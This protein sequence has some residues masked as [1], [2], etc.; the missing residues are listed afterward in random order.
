MQE[1]YHK[2]V[3][4]EEGLAEF[5]SIG[6]PVRNYAARTREEYTRDLRELIAFLHGRG[7]SDWSRVSLWDLQVFLGELDIHGAQ[8]ATR[9]RKAHTIKSLFGFL[10]QAGAI[11]KNPTAELIPPHIPEKERRFLREAEYQALLA[12]VDDSR[13][14]A[15]VIVL[16][17][18]GILLSELVT[19]RTFDVQLPQQ[20]T[21]RPEDVGFIRVRRRR[22]DEVSLPL[23]FK[24]CEALSAWLAEREVWVQ[25]RQL[26]SEALFLS[27]IGTPLT[28]RGIRYRIKQYL[29]R[30]QIPGASVRTLRHTMAAHYLARGGDL[31][32][33]QDML[34][35]AEQ[36][37]EVYANLA[38]KVQ[39]K[40]VQDLAL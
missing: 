35:V 30:A 5:I 1:G 17:Q 26:L 6:M 31:K 25:E 2:P 10:E 8:A 33:V 20:I 36:T 39:R 27:R 14:R 19:L 21:N 37:V 24:A 4:L 40:M 13:D 23:N 38:K 15:I 7:I 9:N 3:S 12:Q 29:T 22:G 34:G 18:T 28:P 32:A 11:A 16:L